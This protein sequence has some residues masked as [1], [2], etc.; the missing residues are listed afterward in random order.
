MDKSSEL[1]VSESNADI[2][3]ANCDSAFT[4]PIPATAKQVEIQ[5][6]LEELAEIIEAE[7]CVLIP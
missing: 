7:G 3:N 5:A 4:K 2:L 6:V 1:L